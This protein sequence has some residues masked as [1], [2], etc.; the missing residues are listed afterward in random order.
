MEPKKC[1]YSIG[2]ADIV[3]LV[4]C[5]LG[6]SFTAISVGFALNLPAVQA[7]STGNAALF[8]LIFGAV[9]LPFLVVGIV[10]AAMSA[11]KR[12][13]IRRVVSE[14]YYVAAEVVNIRPNYSVQ[15]NGQCPYVLEC[16]YRDPAT[17]TLHVFLSR[18]LYF[19]PAELQGSQVRVYVDRARMDRY[20]VD[21]EGALPDVQVH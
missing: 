2:A 17:G 21:V 5:I 15:V 18:N 11:H 14:G 19:C 20:Y 8:P 1:K 16:H 4:F 9:G 12:A 10:T 6:G 13:E 3:A 7:H